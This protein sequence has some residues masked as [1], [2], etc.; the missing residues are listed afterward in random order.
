M[1][2]EFLLARDL[3]E[4][5]D[6]AGPD[7]SLGLLYRDAPGWPTSIGSKKKSRQHLERAVQI[8]PDLPENQIALLET[9]EQWAERKNFEKQLRVTEDTIAKA[10]KLFRGVEWEL[11]WANWEQRAERLRS[12]TIHEPVRTKGTK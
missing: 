12:S 6:F 3:D 7:R 5:V 11:D 1:E 10:R 2:A 9:Y 4:T 8:A